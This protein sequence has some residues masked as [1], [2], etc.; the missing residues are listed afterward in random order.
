MYLANLRAVIG[1]DWVGQVEALP[2]RSQIFLPPDSPLFRFVP[3]IILVCIGE[4]EPRAS[5]LRAAYPV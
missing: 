4:S 5:S 1:L 3:P 2:G